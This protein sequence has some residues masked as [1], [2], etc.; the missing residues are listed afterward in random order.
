MIYQ[1]FKEIIDIINT[2][3]PIRNQIEISPEFA[4]MYEDD[5][6][7]LK[8]I[9]SNLD[10]IYNKI[11]NPLKVVLMGEVKAGKSTIINSIIKEEVSYVNVVE[12][13][14]AI[15]EIEHGY[16]E[17]AV[18]EKIN[19][20]N[21]EGSVEEI[22][23]IIEKNANDQEFFSNIKVV[24]IKKKLKSL[25]KLSI[26]DTPGIETITSENQDR[27]NNYI[28]EADVVI[29]VLNCNH[30]GQLDINQNIEDIYD[31]GKPIILVANRIDEIDAD[32]SEVIEYLDDELG[33]M[34][35]NAIPMSGKMAFDALKSNDKSLLEESGYNALM[36]TIESMNSNSKTI[37]NDSIQRSFNVQMS[38]DMNIHEKIK[39]Y[40]SEI[41]TDINQRLYHFKKYKSDI[42]AE[43][44]MRVN[45]WF[46]DEF[47][48]SE[49]N[50]IIKEKS[51]HKIINYLSDD[52]IKQK[53]KEFIIRL[54]EDI[55]KKW[56]VYTETQ[57]MEHIS[58]IEQKHSDIN[59]NY[60]L[61]ELKISKENTLYK[62]EEIIKEAKKGATIGG[63]I[64]V[65][66][67]GYAAWL[68]PAAAHITILG[69]LGM[70]L[71]PL[72]AGGAIYK[73]I[74]YLKDKS[75]NKKEIEELRQKFLFMK[76]ELKNSYLEEIKNS[77]KDMNQNILDKIEKDVNYNLLKN[78]REMGINDLEGFINEI[79]KYTDSIYKLNQK[80][81][82]VWV[83]DTNVFI[84][85][86]N[87]LD[88][89]DDDEIVVVSKQVLYELDKK[90]SDPNLRKNVQRALTNLNKKQI[91]YED[92]DTSSIP[93]VYKDG[94]DNYILNAAAKYKYMDVT[95][96]T[97]DK[98]LLAKCNAEGIDNMNLE[99]FINSGKYVRVIN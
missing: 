14:A 5:V 93:S 29:W 35:V 74:M 24:K 61:Q 72:I 51:E 64:G 15:I 34:I 86:P 39:L 55:A 28:Q 26:I 11:N 99:E 40:L 59:S 27:T 83:I 73:G 12:A 71:P 87:I 2:K 4:K 43:I 56:E 54:E 81:N 84:D 97:S 95:M 77:A 23:K 46:D 6:A 79:E 13:T 48:V 16:V 88:S 58:Q 17:K 57:I 22:N 67:A 62:E 36:S 52:Y 18:I 90:K 63:K 50:E 82:R 33:Y 78:F 75:F 76:Q 70:V 98:N 68:G 66:V 20:D 1:K 47:L 7:N 49:I 85:E 10:I 8:K 44:D 19:G 21:I 89:F 94:Y 37:Q 31:L 53:I 9:E 3:S 42:D 41:N 30:I 80:S 92:L 69:S 25:D 96:L 32:K 65:A 38:R 45:N 60:Y 91:V